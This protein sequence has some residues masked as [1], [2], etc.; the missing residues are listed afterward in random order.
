[1]TFSAPAV[2]LSEPAPLS[3]AALFQPS[4]VCTSPLPTEPTPLST[5]TLAMPAAGI[6]RASERGDGD[7][8]LAH[9]FPS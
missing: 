7:D 6:A 2:N 3:N 4:A 1:M 5:A 8:E 9:D